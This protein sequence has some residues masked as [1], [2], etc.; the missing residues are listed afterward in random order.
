[1]SEE[2][3]NKQMPEEDDEL[4]MSDDIIQLIN[5]DGETVDFYH[6]G[7]IEY[8]GDWY[9]FF[10]PAEELADLDEDEVA[11]FRLERDENG[12]DVFV[13]LDDD[14]LM[15]KVFDEFN[16]LSEED[17]CCCDD[18]ECDCHHHEHD[19]CECHHDEGCGCK[20]HKD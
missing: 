15:E 20:H 8:E 14:E 5:D 3:E 12:E 7:T 13:P 19:D 11:V 9:V 6:V 4:V 10:Q 16:R 18:D 1:M 2:K 17:G